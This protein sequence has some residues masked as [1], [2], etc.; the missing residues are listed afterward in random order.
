MMD[1]EKYNSCTLPPQTITRYT[2]APTKY[3]L[4]PYGTLCTVY[5][6]DEGT[7]RQLFIQTAQDENDPIWVTV[8]DI[9]IKAYR[10]LFENPCFL[11]DC[12]MRQP[13]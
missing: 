7:A 12:L 9:V 1:I 5:L 13:Q 6:N 8:E 10:P 11:Q 3:D 4:A 2:A